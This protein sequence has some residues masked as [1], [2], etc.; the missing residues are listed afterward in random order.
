MLLVGPREGEYCLCNFFAKLVIIA[1]KS[2]FSF[3]LITLVNTRHVAIYLNKLNKKNVSARSSLDEVTARKSRSYSD[4]VGRARGAARWAIAQPCRGEAG[5]GSRRGGF[6]G[7]EWACRDDRGAHEGEIRR[8]GQG[9]GDS[10]RS[11]CFVLPCPAGGGLS[12]TGGRRRRPAAV[13]PR[14]PRGRQRS[15]QQRCLSAW[16]PCSPTRRPARDGCP[17]QK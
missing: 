14:P 17:S 4:G 11:C 3:V 9:E 5:C 16:G 12:I 10:V 6:P 7:C 1:L 8:A 15:H 13:S 2:G